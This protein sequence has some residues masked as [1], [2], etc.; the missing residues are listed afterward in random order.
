MRISIFA[1]FVCGSPQEG[2]AF[3]NK[4]STAFVKKLPHEN[5]GPRVQ[6]YPGACAH[7]F[8]VSSSSSVQL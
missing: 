4:Y 3:G 2:F 5:K 7:G 8:V 1:T 6:Q